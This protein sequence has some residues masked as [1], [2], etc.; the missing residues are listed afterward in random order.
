M[1]I[2]T[3]KKP[4]LIKSQNLEQLR[5]L[6]LEASS[7]IKAAAKS[8]RSIIIR[9]HDDVDGFSSGIVLEKA[10]LSI[11]GER[12]NIIRSAS[13]TPFFDY[14]DALRDLSHF[15]SR[16][17]LQSPLLILMDL[18]SNIQSLKSV[19][20]LYDYGFEIIIVDHHRHDSCIKDF[21]KIMLNPHLH[22][23][24]SD[25]NAGALSSELALFINP[26]LKGIGHIPALSGIADRSKG[27]DLE[28]YIKLSGFLREE[29]EKWA[30]VLDHD[31]FYLKSSGKP[32]F[33]LSL[34]S[35]DKKNMFR[36][37]SIYKTIINEFDSVK[38]AIKK[39][40]KITSFGKL[41]VIR[42]SKSDIG[43][44]GY[45]SS[46]IA[47]LANELIEGP[48]ITLAETKDSISYR[49]DKVNF[50][51]VSLIDN[52]K[53][54]FPYALVS[55]GGHD[56]AGAIKFNISSKQEVMGYILDYIKEHS[57]EIA[58]ANY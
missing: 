4:F 27:E 18:G 9:H 2:N 44:W 58:G 39:Y 33:L 6:F 29:L 8:N 30:L 10:L 43:D 49:C 13:R 21:S 22:N 46:K 5:P 34:F 11:F 51:G 38:R 54:K 50:S 48:R 42:I 52:L 3:D 56:F 25:L 15:F 17:P 53:K 41:S 24:G 28:K 32:D 20:R 55:G 7:L 36:V 31:L 26:L 16:Q 14:S 37:N 47:R 57:N 45:P 19:Q 1:E 40:V 12:R 35:P 23:M